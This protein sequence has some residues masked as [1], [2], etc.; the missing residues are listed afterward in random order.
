RSSLNEKGFLVDPKNGREYDL[1]DAKVVAS[2]SLED[3]VISDNLEEG[4]AKGTI[5]SAV[6]IGDHYQYLIRTEG[7]EDFLANSPY[8]WNV[9]DIVSVDIAK[10]KIKLRLK[11]DIGAYVVE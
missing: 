8:Q 1:S 7:E 11:K 3:P 5:I 4:L 6:W 2:C 9:G 10:E